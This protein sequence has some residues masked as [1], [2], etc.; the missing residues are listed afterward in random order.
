MKTKVKEAKME[1]IMETIIQTMIEKIREIMR[2]AIRETIRGKMKG[3]IR[4]NRTEKLK[5][6]KL[7]ENV[8]GNINGNIKDNIKDEIRDNSKDNI[9]KKVCLAGVLLAGA[10]AVGGCSLAREELPAKEDDKLVGIYVTKE[11]LHGELPELEIS[12]SGEVQFVQEEVRI[13]GEILWNEGE[14]GR[15]L[16]GISF[17]GAEGFGIYS[18]DLWNEDQQSLAGYSF[19]EEIFQELHLTTGDGTVSME[20]AIYVEET[21]GVGKFYMNPVYQTSDGEIYLMPGSSLSAVMTDGMS[22]SQTLSWEKKKSR[23]GAFGLWGSLPDGDRVQ[24]QKVSFTVHVTCR[25]SDEPVGILFLD[26]GNRIIDELDQEQL[27]AICKGEQSELQIPQETAYLLAEW[28]SGDGS[29]TRTVCNRGEESLFFMRST[30]TG[31]LY[32]TNLALIWE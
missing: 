28:E 6:K 8:N 7:K 10:A 18:I 32:G 12:Q 27:K 15:S 26:E 31:Y 1:T 13:P 23:D 16:S 22:M 14:E 24:S 5:E 4:G 30:G 17:E 2:E 25:Q 20:A 21:D 11:Y 29:V 9:R 3:K 19:Q